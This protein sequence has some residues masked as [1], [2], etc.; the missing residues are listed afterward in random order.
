MALGKEF[1]FGIC[2][3]RLHR[4]EE[5]IAAICVHGI[6]GNNFSAQDGLRRDGVDTVGSND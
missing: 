4:D 1:G 6:N 2:L 5:A 3:Q